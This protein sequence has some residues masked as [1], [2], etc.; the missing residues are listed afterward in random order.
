MR[1]CG[2]VLS[3]TRCGATMA[4][5]LG[6][7]FI[8]PQRCATPSAVHGLR[9]TRVA[10]LGMT[11]H[12]CWRYRNGNYGTLTRLGRKFG[13]SLR[14]SVQAV[15]QARAVCVAAMQFRSAAE[16]FVNRFSYVRLVHNLHTNCVDF[17]LHQ[18]SM[19]RGVWL[20]AECDFN[21]R[22]LRP[23]FDRGAQSQ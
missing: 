7:H 3:P 9:W 18:S 19:R 22:A 16:Q 8:A 5:T 14:R 12:S 6:C 4:A 21:G 23:R 2:G 10:S 1:H 11:I 15:S 13:P 17:G 20:G